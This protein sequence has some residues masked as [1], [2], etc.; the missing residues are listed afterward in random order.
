[1]EKSLFEQ[2]GGTYTQVGDYMLPNLTISEEEQKP[3]GIWGQRRARYLKQHHKVL[4]MN[5]MTSGKLNGYLSDINN[6]AEAMFIRQAKE[7]AEKQGVTEALKAENQM[8]WAGRTNNIC[9][10]ATEFVNSELI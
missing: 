7:M 2:M 10:Q 6:Q 9:N 1:M 3:I 5:L 4:Y 8:E